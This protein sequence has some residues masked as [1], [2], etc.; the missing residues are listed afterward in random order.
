[1]Y[2]PSDKVQ[3]DTF[4]GKSRQGTFLLRRD[5]MEYHSNRFQDY[6]LMV[7][8]KKGQISALL[9]GNRDGSSLISHGGLTYGG[10]LTDYEMTLNRIIP[11]FMNIL[12]Y[13]QEQGFTRLLYKTIPSI[14][15]TIPA[16]ED[17]YCLL[18]LGATVYRRDVLS[19]IDYQYKLN[20]HKRRYRNIHKAR[21]KPL[22]V[23]ETEDYE[24]FWR[25]LSENLLK[26]YALKP[27]HTLEEIEMLARRF[28]DEIKLY[29]SFEGNVLQAGAVVY[30]SPNVCHIQ[31][32]AASEQGKIIS[33]QDI[34]MD[35]LIDA[36]SSSKR[37]F[38]FGASTEEQGKI[39]N[40]GLIEYKESY[41]ARTLVHD[42]YEIDLEK[43]KKNLSF[44]K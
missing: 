35:Y 6:S 19:V 28:P 18:Q 5:Y 20:Y 3:W 21:Q 12:R 4:V 7:F 14:Y 27:V 37:Y 9:P 10:L 42:F 15:H 39:L 31:Y 2:Q 11:I 40:A 32:N 16:Q 43:F 33:A 44:L 22:H 36:F 29:G 26:R 13:I 24:Q 30:L 8:D 25:I 41:G 34:L 38:D 23:Q 17:R 1:M